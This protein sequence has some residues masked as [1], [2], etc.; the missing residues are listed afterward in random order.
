MFSS[1]ETTIR[2]ACDVQERE[3]RFETFHS[4][5]M[6]EKTPYVASAVC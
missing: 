1:T 2:Y 3:S 5:S 6:V 4:W